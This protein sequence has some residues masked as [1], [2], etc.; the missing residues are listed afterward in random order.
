MSDEAGNRPVEQ[1]LDRSA[2]RAF[3]ARACVSRSTT[4]RHSAIMG[5]VFAIDASVCGSTSAPRS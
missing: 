1:R 5:G 3:V 4:T 2:A